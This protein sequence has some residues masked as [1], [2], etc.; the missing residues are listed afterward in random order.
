[1]LPWRNLLKLGGIL[2]A[3]SVRPTLLAS[4]VGTFLVIGC[5]APSSSVP[6]PTGAPA[7]PSPTVAASAE[8]PS[9]V[10]T[11]TLTAAPTEGPATPTLVASSTPAATA[12]PAPPTPTPRLG[13]IPTPRTFPLASLGAIG[14]MIDNDPH[15]RPQTGLS[16][17]D[18]AYE[19]VAEFSLT[20]LMAVYFADAP[21]VVGSMRSTRPYFALAMTEYGGGLAH[22]LDVPGVTSI[23]QA[24]STFNFDVCHGSGGEA[25]FRTTNRVAPFNLYVNARTLAG[26]LRQRPPRQAPAL[27][28]RQPLPDT[29]AEAQ[30]IL[31][32]YPGGHSVRWTWDGMVYERRQDGGA[33]LDSD[34]NIVNTDV[35]VVQRATTAP[36]TYFGEAGYHTVSLIGSGSIQVLAGGRTIVG[37]WSR[38]G[39]GAPT[40]FVD[41][42]GHPLSL[43]PGRVFFQVVPV[44]SE[45]E[46]QL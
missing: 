27:R 36:T 30:S 1:M 10:A 5:A 38:S 11:A 43:P 3:E 33:H 45:V 23:L 40:V 12:T 26:E 24:G 7:V 28:P 29:A 19:I 2:R 34:G 25:A 6:S 18:V 16:A 21:T 13:P 44:E 20:R 41:D 46:I 17:A 37:S 15:A 39:V 9:P 22:C 32:I 8:V 35:V 4:I 31:V 42:L 14:V